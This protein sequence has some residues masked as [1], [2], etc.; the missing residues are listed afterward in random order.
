MVYGCLWHWVYRIPYL[1]IK[2]H[3]CTVEAVQSCWSIRKS[4]SHRH[5]TELLIA[6]VLP[7]SSYQLGR[8]RAKN[9]APSWSYRNG[10]GDVW[11][12][13]NPTLKFNAHNCHKFLQLSESVQAFGRNTGGDRPFWDI[14]LY[15]FSPNS[16]WAATQKSSM[17]PSLEI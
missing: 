3:D 2:D 15:I 14:H 10:F 7:V 1:F 17:L 8:A 9:P 6:Q 11:K 12:W 13:G 16:M 5:S 4:Q